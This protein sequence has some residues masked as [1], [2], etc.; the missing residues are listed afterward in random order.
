M[1]RFFD[2]TFGPAELDMLEAALARWC[3]VHSL[4]RQSTEAA[5]AAEVFINLFREGNSTLPQLE[6]AASRHKWLSERTAI[7]PPSSDSAV[8]SSPPRQSRVTAH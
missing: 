4:S 1:R 2:I 7:Y 8:E 5:L 3:K 6:P